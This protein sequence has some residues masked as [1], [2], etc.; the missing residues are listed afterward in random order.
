M[1]EEIRVKES[2][3]EGRL[4]ELED[5]MEN[6]EAWIKDKIERIRLN[7]DSNRESVEEGN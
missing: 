3:V 6:L 2:E 5:K 1:R 7:S 4:R